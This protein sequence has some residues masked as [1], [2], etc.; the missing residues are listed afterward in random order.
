MSNGTGKRKDFAAEERLSASQGDL[1]MFTV[2]VVYEQPADTKDLQ[3]DA[4]G[5]S[6]QDTEGHAK[7]QSPSTEEP[8]F[9]Q[10]SLTSSAELL[11][12][13]LSRGA[14]SDPD[15]WK[16]ALG[17]PDDAADPPS[18]DHEAEWGETHDDLTRQVEEQQREIETLRK[19]LQ[20]SAD[21]IQA[22]P[23]GLFLF[24]YQPPGELFF[25]NCNPEA[26]RLTGLEQEDCRGVELDEMWPN[27]RGQGLTN[28]FLD[29]A[30]TGKP[31]EAD[32]ALF[33]NS[34]AEKVFR[35]KAFSMPGERLGVAFLDLTAQRR[36]E[37]A[38]RQAQDELDVRRD[39]E[40]SEPVSGN[41]QVES[42]DSRTERSQESAL[43]SCRLAAQEELAGHAARLLTHPLESLQEAA[44][45]ALARL[46]SGYISLV[47]PSL[48][49][50]QQSASQVSSLVTQLRQF[51]RIAP[52]ACLSQ[53]K[54]LDLSEI[55]NESVQAIHCD[56]QRDDGKNVTPVVQE[57]I[58]G[59]DCYVKG[60]HSE[61]LD[62]VNVL[63]KNA[64]EA[65]HRRGSVSVK[66]FS[67][68]DFV[69]LEV[70]DDGA[71]IPEDDV[72]RVFEPFW[73]SK[74]SHTGLGLAA[75]SGVIRRYGGDVRVGTNAG[76]GTTI[77]VRLPR[78]DAP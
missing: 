65:S 58:L 11:A 38:M 44:R 12:S 62:V 45:R 54:A 73:T 29:A 28:A 8:P 49:Q 35:V 69:V 60:E 32:K 71:G 64:L 36:A 21:V 34:K 24:Q 2:S 19:M 23:A 46:E 31:F 70:G 42:E 74:S 67:T 53:C 41:R 10:G 37:E 14:P 39:E 47:R 4:S 66:A 76:Q 18:G 7:C 57:L 6:A 22:I 16:Q 75:V 51:A 43:E 78:A 40:N 25:L 1:E 63:L 5:V 50:I 17:G 48:E 15:E 72:S 33:R 56:V 55:V 77:T 13:D 9:I 61:I 52:A 59:H 26:T 68:D 20:I 3:E 30:R 27:A